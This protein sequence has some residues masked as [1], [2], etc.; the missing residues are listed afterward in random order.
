MKNIF[1]LALLCLSMVCWTE[2]WS[3]CQVASTGGP[4][5]GCTAQ[6]T[7]TICGTM[8][9]LTAPPATTA[10]IATSPNTNPGA[11]P[12]LTITGPN[13]GGS[14]VGQNGG[15]YT[16]CFD[17]TQAA[18]TDAAQLYFF[19]SVLESNNQDG[20]MPMT[21]DC[22]FGI[23]DLNIYDNTGT[24]ISTS[25]SPT[26]LTPGDTYV[27]CISVTLFNYGAGANNIFE[28]TGSSTLQGDDGTTGTGNA[29]NIADGTCTLEDISMGVENF[30][31]PCA[32]TDFSV[33]PVCANDD[34]TVTLSNCSASGNPQDGFLLVYDFD[35]TTPETDAEIY[36]DL[37]GVVDDADLS[38]FGEQSGCDG[39]GFMNLVGFD[40]T[41]CG[42]VQ[43]DLYLVPA[44][45]VNGQVNP[46][47][48]VIGPV[49]LI[50]FP[51]ASAFT[52]NVVAAPD[53]AGT[54]PEVQLLAPDGV[55]VCQSVT[56]TAG[57]D[58]D[59]GCSGA[60]QQ[61]SLVWDFTSEFDGWLTTCN[62]LPANI[63]GSLSSNPTCICTPVELLYVKGEAQADV[64]L[65]EWATAT[66][67]DNSHFEVER[68]VDGQKFVAIGK[69]D[70]AGTTVEE[71]RYEF[72]DANPLKVSYY[73]LKQVDM[74][75]TFEY[76]DVV[77][78]NRVGEKGIVEVFPI[79]TKNNVTVQYELTSNTDVTFTLTDVV[80][81][82]ISQEVI[83]ASEGVNIYTL[84]MT[85]KSTGVYFITYNDGTLEQT[86]RVIK[87]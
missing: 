66:E 50:I 37:T 54:T 56:G 49:P 69:V 46:G 17:W 11:D 68:S 70:G 26:G 34:F 25:A 41:I 61:G 44:D 36:D 82:V 85:T 7:G 8:P 45:L 39:A 18:G 62:T 42:P 72:T 64:N 73:R 9:S 86:R 80:G 14:G 83:T 16:F 59:S 6:N 75:G 51:D 87:N 55:T 78:V 21:N 67:L 10:D 2:A 3:Q 4:A 13:D 47:C 60:G 12:G 84:D 29:P 23:F 35:F 33:D 76:S 20:D 71:Q 32:T 1:T 57:M 28:S 58:M 15:C 81:K 53:C 31:D 38:F 48:S 79:P 74:D 30:T 27:A 24:A 40:V 19:G 22:D 43:I 77:T 65:I 52:V 5:P 63:S